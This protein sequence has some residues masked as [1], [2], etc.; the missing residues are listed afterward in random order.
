M[1]SKIADLEAQVV[2]LKTDM[3]DYEYNNKVLK[4]ENAQYKID[5]NEAEDQ[6]AK[7]EKEMKKLQRKNLELDAHV[8]ELKNTEKRLNADIIM[9]QE[10]ID[11][12][13]FALNKSE[14]E[15]V[16]FR[17]TIASLKAVVAVKGTRMADL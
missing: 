13:N 1:N 10:R 14:R 2:G 8:N 5:L 3:E 12:L 16:G 4:A 9:R 7:G 17:D 15:N 11:N 6:V